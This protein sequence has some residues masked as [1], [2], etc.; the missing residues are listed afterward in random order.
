MITKDAKLLSSTV[1]ICSNNIKY[2]GGFLELMDTMPSLEYVVIFF[3]NLIMISSMM[4]G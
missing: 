2:L 4:I 3:K 1:G